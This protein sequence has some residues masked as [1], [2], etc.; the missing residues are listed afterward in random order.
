VTF[1]LLADENTSHALV[2]ACR[3]LEADFPL[4][5]I[6]AWR[7]GAHRTQKDPALL[8]SLREPGLTL[9]SFDRASLAHHAGQIT[10]EGLGHAGVILFRRS[11][12]LLAYGR[13]A[14][15]LVDFWQKAARE[16]WEDRIAYL[17]LG[18]Q[19]GNFT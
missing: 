17:P 9:V 7:D 11:V 13:Q 6:S 8:M 2:R 3:K 10:R 5:H 12:P 1:R 15:L 19:P 4:T 14:S 18:S 16:D